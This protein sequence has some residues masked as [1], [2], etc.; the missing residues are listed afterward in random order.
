MVKI[1]HS[2]P[3]S[4]VLALAP[5]PSLSHRVTQSRLSTSS[6][7]LRG[8]APL[9]Q[10]G[11]G[12]GLAGSAGPLWPEPGAPTRFPRAWPVGGGVHPTEEGPSRPAD[13]ALGP[14]EGHR[15]RSQALLDRPAPPRS[16]LCPAARTGEGPLGLRCPSETRQ[17]DLGGRPGALGA[18]SWVQGRGLPP[19]GA[20]WL[21]GLPSRG[22][23]IP[24]FLADGS[25]WV[26]C[27]VPAQLPPAPSRSPRLLAALPLLCSARPRPVGLLNRWGPSGTGP[28]VRGPQKVTVLHLGEATGTLGRSVATPPRTTLSTDRS[29]SSCQSLSRPSSVPRRGDLGGVQVTGKG[30]RWAHEGAAHLPC[31]SAPARPTSYPRLACPVPEAAP[32]DPLTGPPT[33][34]RASL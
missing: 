6:A 11:P 25:Q 17:P 19:G 8:S 16:L 33:H 4:L 18:M 15:E 2:P 1:T 22:C 20:H 29:C 31:P 10:R 34:P 3:L 5:S 9:A 23:P 24:S 32:R 7:G 26:P 27:P 28:H 14:R 21:P 13:L 30:R 12:L